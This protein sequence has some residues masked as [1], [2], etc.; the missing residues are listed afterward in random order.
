[1]VTG[2]LR[3]DRISMPNFVKIG[4]SVAKILRFSNFARW[5]P[6]SI[7]DLFGAYLD[8]P[9]WV[10]G[11]LYHS[12]KFG[13]DRC[14]SFYNMNISIFGTFGG[15]S[16][17]TPP[18][19]GFLGN[20]M[21]CNINRSQKRHILAWIRV[22]WLYSFLQKSSLHFLADTWLPYL[23]KIKD[24]E[25]H[26]ITVSWPAA[27]CANSHVINKTGKALQPQQIYVGVS[28]KAEATV[29]AA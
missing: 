5:R 6:S 4:Q 8:N 22:I 17:F 25:I 9:Q 12:A 1:L 21:G 20:L 14:S 3:V 26:P 7:L 24:D 19:L 28:G 13:Y 16:L 27:K 18:K 10:R 23:K 11:G 29:H 15:K 2:V